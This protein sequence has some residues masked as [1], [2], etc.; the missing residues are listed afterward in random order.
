[1]RERQEDSA[2]VP[3]S[4]VLMPEGPPFVLD[5]HLLTRLHSVPSLGT[6]IVLR[7]FLFA[8]DHEHEERA[9]L[10]VE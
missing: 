5:G 3:M 7:Q 9:L 2:W 10:K 8:G 4:A 1:M 6:Q